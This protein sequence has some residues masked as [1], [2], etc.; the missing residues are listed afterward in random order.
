MSATAIVSSACFLVA[1]MSSPAIST[2]FGEP[3]WVAKL[4]IVARPEGFEPPTY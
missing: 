2:L 1:T 4:E 3:C